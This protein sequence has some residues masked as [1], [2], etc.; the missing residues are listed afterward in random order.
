MR[1]GEVLR[2]RSSRGVGSDQLLA[3]QHAAS[4]AADATSAAA[5]AGFGAGA[6]A[7]TAD[8]TDQLRPAGGGTVDDAAG[9]ARSSPLFS[10]SPRGFFVGQRRTK[11][12]RTGSS[13]AWAAFFA[14]FPVVEDRWESF[15][16]VV[17]NAGGSRSH[18]LRAMRS[19]NWQQPGPRGDGRKHK[20]HPLMTFKL[21]FAVAIG[22][23]TL[24][25]LMS[26]QSRRHQYRS[27]RR[28]PAARLSS[29]S[30][31]KH[32]L[33]RHDPRDPRQS[34]TRTYQQYARIAFSTL[35]T[36]AATRGQQSN[37]IPSL[38]P[39]S[40]G[41]ST[42]PDFGPLRYVSLQQRREEDE[43]DSAAY[44]G[45]ATSSSSLI[46]SFFRGRRIRVDDREVFESER[47]RLLYD[48]DGDIEDRLEHFEDLDHTP[49]IVT[50]EN[51]ESN[52][53]APRNPDKGCHKLKW[54]D[55]TYPTCNLFHE[56][57][58]DRE[59]VVS[60]GENLQPYRRRYLA[61]GAFR[62]AWLFEPAVNQE[63][64]QDG[65]NGNFVLKTGRFD[66][67][68]GMDYSW[69]SATGVFMEAL[70]ME[71][72]SSH[73]QIADLFGH[74]YTSLMVQQ[75]F[76][77]SQQIVSGE[78]YNGRG[79]IAQ[80]EL[81]ELQRR[82]VHPLNNFAVEQKLDIAISMAEAIAVLH[83]H[84]EGV[85]VNDDVHPDQ[86]LLSRPEGGHV[87][88]NDF[89]NARVLHWNPTEQRYC[90]FDQW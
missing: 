62:D 82:D 3:H 17:A 24:L 86:Y 29:S 51:K 5:A 21:L 34:R 43:D 36:G 58:L 6:A 72:M 20:K 88:M 56:L 48:V 18:N 77:I 53:D 70:I 28:L 37:R 22:F 59:T 27:R 39:E 74:C 11:R 90:K 64:S 61:H 12:A 83:G 73:P 63:G 40:R 54:V 26:G 89:S 33:L 79:R 68:S 19:R 1:S 25:F 50:D 60:A 23:G 71:R 57:S 49:E 13:R 15:L 69:W 80:A 47:E 52:L 42:G 76:E 45:S 78:E 66:E 30:S 16:R 32:Q 87:F 85:I 10:S 65:N 55:D 8:R 44:G 7:T 75:G 84:D 35:E 38:L 67:D 2:R 81:N 4:S 41:A 31:S 9:A 46:L 14:R